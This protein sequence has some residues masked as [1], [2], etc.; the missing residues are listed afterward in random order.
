MFGKKSSLRKESTVNVMP[1][2]AR[3]SAPQKPNPV[4]VHKRWGF[5]GLLSHHPVHARRGDGEGVA[6]A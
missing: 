5:E 3:R 6:V 4:Q 1:S 2:V